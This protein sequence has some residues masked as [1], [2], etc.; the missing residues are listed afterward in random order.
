MGEKRTES[1]F[2]ERNKKRLSD[3][4][5]SLESAKIIQPSGNY[6][7][8]GASAAGASALGASAAGAAG[9]AAGAG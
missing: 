1:E 4:S 8:L 9:A 5:E 3:F 6:S 2:L 7:A